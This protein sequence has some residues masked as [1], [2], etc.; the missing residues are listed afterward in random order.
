[1]TYRGNHPEH[2]AKGYDIVV[3]THSRTFRGKEVRYYDCWRTDK[4]FKH[5]SPKEGDEPDMGFIK[6]AM[7]IFKPKEED[8]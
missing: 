4:D 8:E 5:S 2:I 1:M 3:Y 7:R 6:R